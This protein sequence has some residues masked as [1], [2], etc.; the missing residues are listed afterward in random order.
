MRFMDFCFA[1]L[2]SANDILERFGDFL[3]WVNIFQSHEHDLNSEI[4]GIGLGLD[5]GLQI[6]GGPGFAT[7][8]DFE[9]VYAHQ[10][11]N[12]LTHRDALEQFTGLDVVGGVSANVLNLKL[13]WNAHSKE[14]DRHAT[15]GS[16]VGAGAGAGF[17]RGNHQV[18]RFFLVFDPPG[19]GVSMVIVDGSPNIEALNLVSP[20]AIDLV[21]RP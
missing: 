4:Q 21:D 14:I 9:K 17:P 2:A 3:R 5:R 6:R 12:D 11:A 8:H 7:G 19:D 16:R 1:L 18:E 10:V 20:E 15:C 13:H